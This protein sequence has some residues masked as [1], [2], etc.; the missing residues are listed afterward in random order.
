MSTM[1]ASWGSSE[2]CTHSLG[3]SALSCLSSPNA[4][5]LIGGTPEHMSVRLLRPKHADTSSLAG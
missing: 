2:H 5:Q 4:L 3:A 1:R